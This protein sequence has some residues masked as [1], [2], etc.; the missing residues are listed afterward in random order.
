MGAVKNF[1]KQGAGILIHDNGTTLLS[2]YHQDMLHGYNVAIFKDGSTASLKYH[3]DVITEALFKTSENILFIK[4]R[5][6]SPDGGAVLLQ[7]KESKILY[8]NYKMGD[9][10]NRCY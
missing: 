4:Y 3:K 7:L 2:N 6:G 9:L 5:K 10:V 1:Q 8:L